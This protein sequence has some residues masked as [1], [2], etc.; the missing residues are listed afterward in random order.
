MCE[1]EEGAASG[2]SQQKGL[3]SRRRNRRET[4][5]LMAGL[6]RW[7]KKPDLNKLD[8]LNGGDLA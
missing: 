3:E 7:H 1:L 6:G 4:P 5:L 8:W 2:E